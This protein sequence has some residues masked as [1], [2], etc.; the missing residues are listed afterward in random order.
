MYEK[1]EQFEGQWIVDARKE[2]ERMSVRQFC[3]EVG[4]G[5]ATYY[6]L[7]HGREVKVHCYG[8]V[9]CYVRNY[10]PAAY[11]RV[12]HAL[13]ERLIKTGEEKS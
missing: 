5:D 8:K 4:I 7:L 12:L 10:A 6:K 2:F 3:T 13:G 9:L 1:K 11:E